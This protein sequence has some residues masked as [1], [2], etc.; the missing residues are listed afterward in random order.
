V[1]R[2]SRRGDKSAVVLL[3][4]ATT[5]VGS[6]PIGVSSNLGAV[7]GATA[8]RLLPI[9]RSLV[10]Q[11]LE[12]ALHKTHTPSELRRIEAATY[13]HLGMLGA[14]CLALWRRGPEWLDRQIVGIEGLD[15]AQPLLDEKKPFLVVTGHFGNWEMLGAYFGSRLNLSVLAKP[16]HNR[17]VDE[18]LC[19]HRLRHGLEILTS[20]E[21]T[22]ARDILRAVRS[23]R[24]VCFVA[25]QDARRSGIFVPF[26]GRPASTFAG[27]AL[28][29]MRLKMPLVPTFLLR[30]G[31]G[32]HRVVVRPP[33]Y[34]PDGLP[35]DE[36]VAH[37]TMAH[38]KELE[39]MIRL[40]PSQY[41]WFHRR[42]KTA[43]RKDDVVHGPAL[44]DTPPFPG[45]QK[46]APD[47]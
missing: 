36:A 16:M 10:R 3:R 1:T 5:A 26:L 32:R 17:A 33:L 18:E 39:D 43:P 25:D 7:V 8:Y 13:R 14:E 47:D 37:L 38:V 44:P 35:L 12:H 29:A 4:V 11:N 21:K 19:A 2:P 45:S 46:D 24:T 27:P 34:P 6:L 22:V 15:H 41:F 20:T 40:T 9:R 42:W 23:E 31:P 28:M 30:L